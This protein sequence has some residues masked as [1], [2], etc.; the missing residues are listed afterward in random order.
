MKNRCWNILHK[1]RFLDKHQLFSCCQPKWNLK[2]CFLSL[3]IFHAYYLSLIYFLFAFPSF[4]MIYSILESLQNRRK[5]ASIHKTYTEKKK[6]FD[7]N[8][9][10]K[11]VLYCSEKHLEFSFSARTSRLKSFVW[12]LQHK[13]YP[14]VTPT[15]IFERENN[16]KVGG[17]FCLYGVMQK[18]VKPR[19]ALPQFYWYSILHFFIFFKFYKNIFLKTFTLLYAEQEIIIILHLLSFSELDF[20]SNYF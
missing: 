19:S 20:F 5:F 3:F 12:S 8:F 6:V 13:W 16:K 7:S 17:F 15:Y 18:R 1:T 2:N 11:Y 14:I 10:K 4:P 9:K